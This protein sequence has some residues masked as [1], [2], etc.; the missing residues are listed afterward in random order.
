MPDTT[1]SETQRLAMPIVR[2]GR[3]YTDMAEVSARFFVKC[4]RLWLRTIVVNVDI[5]SIEV[6]FFSPCLFPSSK[7][8]SP[9][10]FICHCIQYLCPDK[11]TFRQPIIFSPSLFSLAKINSCLVKCNISTIV[12]YHFYTISMPTT[13]MIINMIFATNLIEVH[14][15]KKVYQRCSLQD[16]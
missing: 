11:T 14:F 9:I 13:E 16:D 2:H 10:C 5:R 8:N 7:R 3:G 6:F 1:L 4:H 12:L 15:F